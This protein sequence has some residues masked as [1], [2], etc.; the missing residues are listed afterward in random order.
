MQ[1][2]RVQAVDDLSGFLMLRLRVLCWVEAPPV[3]TFRDGARELD[4]DVTMHGVVLLVPASGIQQLYAVFVPAPLVAGWLTGGSP[5]R[6]RK[7]QTGGSRD[8]R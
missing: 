3:L 4:G 5:R 7:Q 1:G 6:S 2:D 8:K